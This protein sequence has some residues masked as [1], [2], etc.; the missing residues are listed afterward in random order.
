MIDSSLLTLL[1]FLSRMIF[2]LPV[3]CLHLFHHAPM[4]VCLMISLQPSFSLSFFL[5]FSPTP[6]LIDH[7]RAF[8]MVC[9][10]KHESKYEYE[11]GFQFTARTGFTHTSGH[12]LSRT[13]MQLI[14]IV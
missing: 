12:S 3:Q 10:H 6:E 5:S 14:I 4:L 2:C 11:S 7:I 8:V 9:W 1:C 13:S